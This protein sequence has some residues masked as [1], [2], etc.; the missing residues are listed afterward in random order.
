MK[1]IIKWLETNLSRQKSPKPSDAPSDSETVNPEEI[2]HGID[3]PK[4][5]QNSAK[6]VPLSDICSDESVATVPNLE[7]LDESSRDTDNSIAFNPYDT[8]TIHKK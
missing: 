4:G 6:N 2:D 8:A 1:R 7:I 5:L 3:P